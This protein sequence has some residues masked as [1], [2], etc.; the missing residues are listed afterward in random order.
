MGETDDITEAHL[1]L[2]KAATAGQQHCI[3]LIATA[4]A[5]VD[6]AR[7]ATVGARKTLQVWACAIKARNAARTGGSQPPNWQPVGLKSTPMVGGGGGSV[8]GV[9]QQPAARHICKLRR[10]GELRHTNFARK[11]SVS[12]LGHCGESEF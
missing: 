12:W 4:E 5:A 2:L 10:A 9:T 7:T 1:E 6:A 8:E 3:T 11:V